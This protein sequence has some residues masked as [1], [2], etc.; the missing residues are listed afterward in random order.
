[1][2][3]GFLVLGSF[4]DSFCVCVCN[5]KEDMFY[6]QSVNYNLTNHF[7]TSIAAKHTD[8]TTNDFTDFLVRK[9]LFEQYKAA[10]N[11]ALQAGNTTEAI[12][13]Y[14]KAID[15]DGTNHVYFS[16]RSAAYLK[17]GEAQVRFVS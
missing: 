5:V 13:Q 9:K 3:E 1:M 8:E 16:N 17:K 14:S 4:F 12:A 6:R 15:A 2:M 10:G 7:T 11:K